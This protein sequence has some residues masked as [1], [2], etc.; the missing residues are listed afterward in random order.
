MTRVGMF[1]ERNVLIRW[2]N[3]EGRIFR[4]RLRQRRWTAIGFIVAV[5]ALLAAA[6]AIL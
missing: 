5:A 1:G 3:E 6:L 2:R 4:A